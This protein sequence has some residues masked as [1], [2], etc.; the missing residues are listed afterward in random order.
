MSNLLDL[1]IL[2]SN[3]WWKWNIKLILGQSI[4]VLERH[5]LLFG[6]SITPIP[7]S[8]YTGSCSRVYFQYSPNIINRAKWAPNPHFF[9][10]LHSQISYSHPGGPYRHNLNKKSNDHC[11]HW[12]AIAS[13]L[14]WYNLVFQSW[15]TVKTNHSSNTIHTFFIQN[16]LKISS[17]IRISNILR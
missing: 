1:E 16:L 8:L 10:F 2:K 5:F 13:S 4:V 7:F 12:W 17:F 9:R 3:Y 6:S 11:A 14:D 15:T